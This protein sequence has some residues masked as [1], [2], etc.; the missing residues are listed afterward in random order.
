MK[1]HVSEPVVGSFTPYRCFK[2]KRELL[3]HVGMRY[4]FL[5]KLNQIEDWFWLRKEHVDHLKTLI[6]NNLKEMVSDRKYPNDVGD[7]L[8]GLGFTKERA[9][10]LRKWITDDTYAS[11][12]TVLYFANVYLENV[13]SRRVFPL[14][15]KIRPLFHPPASNSTN[16]VLFHSTT[17]HHARQIAVNGICANIG[18]PCQD[19]SDNGG[20][21][22]TDNL[23]YAIKWAELRSFTSDPAI[24]VYTLP[25]KVIALFKGLQLNRECQTD[26]LLWRTIVHYNHNGRQ[27][28][29]DK[30]D[31]LYKTSKHDDYQKHVDY[32]IGPVSLYGG[33]SMFSNVNQMCILTQ[34]MADALC[35]DNNKYLCQMYEWGKSD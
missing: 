35:F 30:M 31:Y 7:V 26:M 15:N 8:Y 24:L 25:R 21:Y 2:T 32:I 10:D 5:S 12:Q 22:L 6:K 20:F 28:Q 27:E 4:E 29:S 33:A 19:F 18:Q 34:H 11:H 14:C 3:C 17:R 16:I 23:E 1:Q 13:L 9:K